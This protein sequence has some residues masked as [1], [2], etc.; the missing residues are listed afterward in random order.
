MRSLTN[1]RFWEKYHHLPENVQIKANNV[2]ELWKHDPY[3][4]N[5]RFKKVHHKHDIYSIR[6]GF[7]YRSLG[8]KN[9]DAIIWFWI[10]S[11]SDYEKM[12]KEF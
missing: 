3:N 10:G 4:I 11:H 7:D 6:I 2:F 5:L 12:L 1:D 8:L 9:Q